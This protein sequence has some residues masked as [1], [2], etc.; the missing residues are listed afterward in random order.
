MT[1]RK[2]VLI[3]AS[4]SVSLCVVAL[5]AMLPLRAIKETYRGENWM[6]KVSGDTALASLSIPGSHDA[7]AFHSFAD[8]S[9]K[10]Q[11]LSIA[12]QLNAGARFFDIRLQQRN[13]VL[14]VVHGFVDQ[15]LDFSSTLKDF[16]KFLKNHT[17]EALIVSVKMESAP[18][19]TNVTFD[20][21]LKTALLPY[22]SIWN[23]TG[24][25]PATL[26]EAR[27]KIFLVSRYENS[28]IGLP[29]YE[30]WLDP[31]E[32]TSSN[33]FDIEKSNLHVQ[34]HYKVIDIEIKKE[35]IR[36]CFD[37]SEKNPSKLTLNFSSCYYVNNF[38]PTYAGTTAKIVNP[39]LIKE[40]NNRKNLGIIV[41]DFLTSDLCE[42]I[43]SRNML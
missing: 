16:Q 4:M 32:A 37:Y 11:D 36:A 33:T 6:K 7:G 35:E 34:D 8:L 42:A 29:A 15:D 14:K 39:W 23:T 2:H 38:P 17:S 5:L 9:G 25:L 22:T 30:G 26:K 20:E 12:E 41:S 24:V 40:I 27:G 18:Q 31:K 19:N 43:Y 10:C 28:S 1:N 3:A 13:N 21:S